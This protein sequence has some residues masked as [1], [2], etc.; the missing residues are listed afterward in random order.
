MRD[1]FL[2]VLCSFFQPHAQCSASCSRADV[3]Y[4][5]ADYGYVGGYYGASEEVGMME[6]LVKHGPFVVALHVR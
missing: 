4:A 3:Y 1:P 5:E 2:L 6:E